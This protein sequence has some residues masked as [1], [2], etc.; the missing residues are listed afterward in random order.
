M[1][2]LHQGA[3]ASGILEIPGIVMG[4]FV[5]QAIPEM[6]CINAET[7]NFTKINTPPWVFFMF[8]KYYKWYQILQ[9][10]IPE[11]SGNVM[12]FFHQGLSIF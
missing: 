7:Y 3:Q 4:F 5:C 8:F 10:T 12:G 11:K 2:E 1:K 6:H 9:R